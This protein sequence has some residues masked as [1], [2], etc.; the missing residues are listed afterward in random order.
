MNKKQIVLAIVL[1]DFVLFTGYA[2]YE[3][4]VI[5]FAEMM[6]AN[7]VTLQVTIDLVI[8]LGLFAIWMFQDARDRGLFAPGYLA[9]IAFTGSIGALIYLIR[10]ESVTVPHS[11]PHH[12]PQATMA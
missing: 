2:L 6:V 10:R 8:A 12:S 3:Y 4:G 7:A 9:L 5:G 1:A 11:T